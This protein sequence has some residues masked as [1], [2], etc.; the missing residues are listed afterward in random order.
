MTRTPRQQGYW[1]GWCAGNSL[2]F[3][4]HAPNPHTGAAADQWADG[5]REGFQAGQQDHRDHMISTWR[6]E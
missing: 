3:E 6:A 1:A 4:G 5:Y 2:R